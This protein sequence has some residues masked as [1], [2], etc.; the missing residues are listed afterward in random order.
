MLFEYKILLSQKV[1]Y[2]VLVVSSAFLN[3]SS[4]DCA[5]MKI[6]FFWKQSL[7]STIFFILSG[8][9]IFT[10][11]RFWLARLSKHLINCSSSFSLPYNTA[12]KCAFSFISSSFVIILYKEISG[13]SSATK[14]AFCKSKISI[15]SKISSLIFSIVLFF[16]DQNF[17]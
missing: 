16:K 2:L 10:P 7:S 1:I 12:V 9:I 11:T 4:S 15:F 14:D 8:K 3:N 5:S 13:F 6:I 17:E